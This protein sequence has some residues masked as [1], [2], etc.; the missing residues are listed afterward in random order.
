MSSKNVEKKFDY[1]AIIEMFHNFYR[2]N[3]LIWAEN[4][5]H[6]IAIGILFILSSLIPFV[7]SGLN[8]LLI[9]KFVEIASGT[10]VDTTVYYLVGLVVLSYSVLPLIVAYESHISRI[11]YFFLEKKFQLDILIK[12]ANLDIATHEDP[13]KKDLI[14]KVVDGGIW[15]LQNFVDRQFYLI[16]N[17]VE[18]IIASSIIA[19]SEVWILL[20]IFVGLIP[21]LINEIK[22]GRM[23]WNI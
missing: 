4:K 13:S 2:C 20:I 12:L 3:R 22:F 14:T 9:N 19:Y 21:G 17:I 6:L 5:Y 23:I 1:N 7:R 18:I 15:R 8:A 16:Q 11:F 10:P